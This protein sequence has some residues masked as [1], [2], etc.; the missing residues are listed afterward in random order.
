[1][2]HAGD[3]ASNPNAASGREMLFRAS[4]SCGQGCP[5]SDTDTLLSG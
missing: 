4:H 5:R 1:M 2:T 3:L